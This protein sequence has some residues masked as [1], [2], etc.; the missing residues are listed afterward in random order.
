[1]KVMMTRRLAGDAM[2]IGRRSLTYKPASVS[3][4]QKRREFRERGGLPA[5]SIAK[6]TG[7]RLITLSEF[8]FPDQLTRRKWQ[9]YYAYINR[10]SDLGL[11]VAYIEPGATAMTLEQ[12]ELAKAD[13]QSR[14]WAREE[15]RRA[16]WG[17][18]GSPAG[19]ADPDYDDSESDW[20]PTGPRPKTPLKSVIFTVQF[21][22]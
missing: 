9:K 15:P 11:E 6:C 16:K 5:Y 7:V 20:A 22:L 4:Y 1:M 19:P 14:I 12:L 10:R 8:H 13:I 3:D 18:L 17:K 2:E 21:R